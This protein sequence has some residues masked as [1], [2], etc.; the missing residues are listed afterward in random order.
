MISVINICQD[1]HAFMNS[2]LEYY[3]SVYLVMKTC[4]LKKAPTVVCHPRS[5]LSTLTP[6]L[7]HS[8]IKNLSF[9]IVK[10]PCRIGS[11]SL[12]YCLYPHSHDL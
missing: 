8:P 9:L 11:N 6:Q 1:P 10:V 2:R 12:K 3:G 7:I 5:L 4:A